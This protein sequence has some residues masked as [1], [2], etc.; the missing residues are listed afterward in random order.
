M[1]EKQHKVVIVR[2]SH[3]RGC[4]AEVKHL[5][6]NSF[7]VLGLINSG[8]GMEGIKDTVSEITSINLE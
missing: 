7:E 5:L 2:D 8:S 3:A 4:A 6:K 1:E